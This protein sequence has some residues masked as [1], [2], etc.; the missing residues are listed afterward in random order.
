MPV[1]A[2]FVFGSYARQ[3]FN[4][5]SDI[6]ILCITEESWQSNS[7]VGKINVSF[8]PKHNF[9]LSASSGDLF[10]LHIIREAKTIYDPT[11]LYYQVDKAFE[12]K[13]S[14]NV[15]ISQAS[16]LGR[17][18]INISTNSNFDGAASRIINKRIAWCARTILI[19]RSVAK[20][21]PVFD[22]RGLS[23]FA[24]SRLIQDLL[25][26]KDNIAILQKDLLILNDLIQDF[27]ISNP[28]S[29]LE[30]GLVSTLNHF[31]KTNNQ[32]GTKTLYQIYKKNVV[33]NETYY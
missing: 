11:S 31:R 14:Y 30:K 32:L 8:F 4:E 2:Q 22:A 15:E 19:A 20:G 6:D 23:K 9:L 29:W 7:S 12:Y 3:D 25:N 28:S 17:F 27:G 24:G 18:L 21:N 10:I 5:K 26:H 33:I 16:D 1:L 13:S